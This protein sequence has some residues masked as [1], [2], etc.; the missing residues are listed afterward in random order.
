MYK[1]NNKTVKDMISKIVKKKTKK[2]L[3][4]NDRFVE[5]VCP[6]CNN[7]SHNCTCNPY[8]IHECDMTD[9]SSCSD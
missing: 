6:D 4:E 9:D 3:I 1:K 2:I 5:E 8:P 7:V